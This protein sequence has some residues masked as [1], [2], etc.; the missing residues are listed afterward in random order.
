MTK[1]MTLA[2]VN[3]PDFFAMLFVFLLF[4]VNNRCEFREIYVELY[5]DDQYPGTIFAPLRTVNKA[6]E[7]AESHQHDYLVN[8][9]DG[10]FAEEKTTKITHGN[11]SLVGQGIDKTII[12]NKYIG[13]F[14]NVSQGP[15]AS[16][17]IHQLTLELQPQWVDIDRFLSFETITG[18]FEMVECQMNQTI[19]IDSI[20]AQAFHIEAEHILISHCQ[21]NNLWTNVSGLFLSPLVSAIIEHSYFRRCFTQQFAPI[22]INCNTTKARFI[23]SDCIFC[24][25]VGKMGG[26]FYISRYFWNMTFINNLFLHNKATYTYSTAGNDIYLFQNPSQEIIFD[27]HNRIRHCFSNSDRKKIGFSWEPISIDYDFLL[28]SINNQDLT[29]LQEK[30]K[31]MEEEEEQGN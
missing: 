17:F 10:I 4:I 31:V 14:L 13:Q 11:I 19:L 5:G 21:F 15:V 22:R 8:V 9:G 24:G 18:N 6:I 29:D 2:M 23:V 1:F 26:A 27:F 20:P 3:H 12:T 16:L 25:C 7:I 30:A 28:P